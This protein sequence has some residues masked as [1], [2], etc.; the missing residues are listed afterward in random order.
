MY[1][2]MTSSL[3]EGSKGTTR[4]HMDMADALNIMTY[5]SPC[6]DGSLGCAAW[7]LFRAED[8]DKLRSFLRKRIQGIGI[9][10]PIHSQQIYLD[11]VLKKELWETQG[12]KSYRIYQRPGEAI[13]IP[14][15]CAHQVREEANENRRLNLTT[16]KVANLADCVKVAIDFVSPENVT[17]C[18]QLTQEFR[19][20]NQGLKWK[21][22]VLQLKTMMWFAW[23]SCAHEEERARKEGRAD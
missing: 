2:A 7:D 9:Q 12:V 18:E 6:P 15:G 1:N 23:L 21:E 11:E 16:F 14:A 19:E 20:Q 3:A 10:D 13:F 8:S 17:R 4:L 22:D 5:A